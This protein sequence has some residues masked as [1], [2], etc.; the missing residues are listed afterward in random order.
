MNREVEQDPMFQLLTDAL[1]AGPGSPAWRD[2]VSKLKDSAGAT[3]EYSL[4]LQARERLESGKEWR[5]IR[6]GAGFTRKVMDAIDREDATGGKGIPTAKIVG[7]I[8]VAVLITLIATG[9]YYASNGPSP[10]QSAISD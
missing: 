3:D 9:I 4:I 7:I 10:E 8:A 2:A 6:A 5:S 1:R